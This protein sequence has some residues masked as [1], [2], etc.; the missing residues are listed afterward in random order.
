M[1]VVRILIA[2][3]GAFLLGL[4]AVN[5]LV[6]RPRRGLAYLIVLWLVVCLATIVPWVWIAAIAIGVVGI[7]EAVMQ[8]ARRP[9]ALRRGPAL[10]WA[11]GLF[12]LNVAALVTLRTFVVEAFRV[13]ST[14]MAP[15]L[16]I[17]DHFFVN[18]LALRI[19]DIER[20]DIITYRYPCAP[21]RDYVK[22][23]IGLPGDH[24]EVRCTIVY[25]NGVALAQTPIDLDHCTYDDLFE[26]ADAWETIRCTRFREQ[27]GARGHDL[28]QDARRTATPTPD[29]RDFPQADEPSPSCRGET[30]GDDVV[31]LG[32]IVE[33]SPAAQTGECA[34]QRYYVVPPGHVF[35]LGDNRGNSKDSRYTGAVPTQSI[36]GVVNGIWLSSGKRLDWSRIGRV[37]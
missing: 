33:G 32:E 25:I 15:T 11:T 22:R 9:F 5:A 17:G 4:G 16:Q 35:V 29:S 26:G 13:P 2:L 7:G 14:G 36:I 19:R 6:G 10:L 24:V 21:E 18:K 34:P 1:R 37:R 27:I 3:V 12:V 31:P 28:F 23:V 8:A 30:S 20:G